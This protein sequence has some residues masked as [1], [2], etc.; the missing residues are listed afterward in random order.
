MDNTG[1]KISNENTTNGGGGESLGGMSGSYSSLAKF[2][3]STSY[4]F[5]WVSRGAVDLAENTWMGDGYTSATNRTNGRRVAMAMFSDKETKVSA[6]ASSEV[7]AT[8][9]DSQVNWVTP[10]IGP[11]R[12][13]A[14]VAVF[15][16]EY[17]LI[18]YEE[19]ADPFCDYVAMG[20]SGTFTGTYYQLVNT[21]GDKIGDAVKSLDTYVAGDM[22]TLGNGTICWPYVNMAWQ[23]NDAVGGYGGVAD[24]TTTKMSFAC[25]S[26]VG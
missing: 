2:I 6:Q 8:D 12:S 1:V 9:G 24:T 10:T 21:A 3:N 20:C 26:L 13:N 23:L 15:D 16:D 7:G 22:V 5:T 4:I 18:S 11:D 14:H 25:M 19:I 17:A